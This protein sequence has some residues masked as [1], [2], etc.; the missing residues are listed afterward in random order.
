MSGSA[1]FPAARSPTQSNHFPPPYSPTHSNR[2]YYNHEYPQPPP[3]H[4]MQTP[5]PFPP[6][7][8]VHSP[9]HARPGLTSPLPPPSSSL[10]PP[11]PGNSTYQPLTSSPPYPIQRT[12]AGHMGNMPAPYEG[13]PTSHAHPSSRQESV[14]QSPI[15]EHHP[16]P[17]GLLREHQASDLRPQSKE[18]A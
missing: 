9:H 7:S 14:L 12:Y 11:P 13:T 1:P 18:V 16:M 8:L 17:N 10:P 15:R 5:P 6:A 2:P 4:V 3:Q